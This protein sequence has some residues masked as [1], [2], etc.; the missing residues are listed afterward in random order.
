MRDFEKGMETPSKNS[1]THFRQFGS[2]GSLKE[3]GN[4][5]NERRQGAGKPEKW[6]NRFR[7]PWFQGKRVVECTLVSD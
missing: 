1:T 3:S 2:L 7:S 4:E 5:E 6:Y